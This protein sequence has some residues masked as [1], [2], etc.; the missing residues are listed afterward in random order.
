MSLNRIRSNWYNSH[1]LSFGGVS[2]CC[3][4]AADEQASIKAFPDWFLDAD[5]GYRVLS[6]S[7]SL[8][9]APLDLEELRNN[10]GAFLDRLA[11]ATD[12]AGG[13]QSAPR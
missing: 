11:S 9:P 4:F 8:P 7:V 2:L 10:G 13:C 6:G 3:Q 1:R 5:I 12:G